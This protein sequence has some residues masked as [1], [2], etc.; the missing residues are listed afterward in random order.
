[1]FRIIH[2][3]LKKK[4]K[5]TNEKTYKKIDKAGFFNF[6]MHVCHLYYKEENPKEKKKKIYKKKTN[7]K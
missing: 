6:Y 5:K 4:H 7:N 3:I 2:I 1:M